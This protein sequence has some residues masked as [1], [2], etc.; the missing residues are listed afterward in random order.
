V[1]LFGGITSGFDL[2]LRQDTAFPQTTEEPFQ[3]AFE[4]AAILGRCLQC[5]DG[6]RYGALGRG[7]D[8]QIGHTRVPVA[9]DD[10]GINVPF[11]DVTTDGTVTAFI[12]P[13][14]EDRRV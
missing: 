14:R 10:R 2:L 6:I 8:Y 1:A 12:V 5:G 3:T 9:E 11:E 4:L 13:A 7:I